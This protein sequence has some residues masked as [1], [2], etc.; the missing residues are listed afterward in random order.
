MDEPHLINAMRKWLPHGLILL[1]LLFV[2]IAVWIHA[3]KAVVPPLYDAFGYF[4]KG[5]NFWKD[6][7]SKELV[8][9]RSTSDQFFFPFYVSLQLFT[10]RPSIA[11]CQF[12]NSGILQSWRLFFPP[13]LSSITSKCLICFRR[14]TSGGLL[15]FFLLE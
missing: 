12:Q 9:G 8:S 10:W 4:Q 14:R 15:I 6:L 13:C 5:Q 1:W 2:G 11:P 7:R 3:R